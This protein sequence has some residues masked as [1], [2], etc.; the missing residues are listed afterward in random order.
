MGKDIEFPQEYEDAIA[1]LDWEQMRIDLEQFGRDS[2]YLIS[3]GNRMRKEHPDCWVAVYQE[4]VVGVGPDLKEM[5]AGL[6]AR[7]IPKA[8]VAVRYISKEPMRLIV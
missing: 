2:D 5:L 8:N 6:D 4:K 3:I 1:S 7:G